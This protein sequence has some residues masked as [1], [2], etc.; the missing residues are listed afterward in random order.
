[1][2]SRVWLRLVP[3][4]CCLLPGRY[5]GRLDPDMNPQ[6]L[7]EIQSA[8]TNSAFYRAALKDRCQE[9]CQC[10]AARLSR[11]PRQIHLSRHTSPTPPLAQKASLLVLYGALLKYRD[12]AIQS[13]FSEDRTRKCI[14]M[15]I[16]T[17]KTH[18]FRPHFQAFLE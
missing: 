12:S 3:G 10:Q 6:P 9:K 14:K 18:L 2:S 11:L 17:N 7:L 5:V 13:H 8:S 15:P 4:S 1:M 16:K